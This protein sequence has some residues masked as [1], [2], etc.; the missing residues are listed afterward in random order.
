MKRVF[1]QVLE[2]TEIPGR[3]V[4]MSGRTSTRALTFKFAT[5]FLLMIPGCSSESDDDP[6]PNPEPVVIRDID[7]VKRKYYRLADPEIVGDPTITPVRNF[8][9]FLDDKNP[10]NDIAE[11]ARET[12]A[13]MDA[14]TGTQTDSTG[15][16][17]GFFHR[18]E[19]NQDYQVN[20]TTGEVTL[21][22]P[23]SID[24][25]LAMFYIRADGDTVGDLNASGGV[26]G[27]HQ[28][29]QILAPPQWEL[30]DD[31]KG[32]A[33]ARSFEMKNVYSLQAKNLVPESLEL[34]I[35]RKGTVAGEQNLD[36]QDDPTNPANIAEYVRILGLDHK[37]IN[38]PEPD[39]KVEAEFLDF[40]EGTLTFPNIT[41]FAPDSSSVN[42]IANPV[43][44]STGRTSE[45]GPKLLQYNSILYTQEPSD[46]AGQDLYQIEARYTTLPPP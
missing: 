20:M 27:L 13:F 15:V 24:Q 26:G 21:E 39:L 43:E 32:F 4:H 35:R 1:Y 37:G 5:I 19:V 2:Q 17:R 46:F 41:P 11:G 10:Q 40:V 45:P 29:L 34:V 22:S 38:T 7:Y 16:Y 36:F 8:E 12:F 42:V 14:R 9:L 31:A 18:L 33:P 23:L 25:A 30:Y 28:E 6:D 3:G 44:V